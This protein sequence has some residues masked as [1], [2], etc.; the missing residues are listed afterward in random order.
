MAVCPKFFR[1]KLNLLYF[2][3]FKYFMC[4]WIW[5]RIVFHQSFFVEMQSTQLN[6]EDFSKRAESFGV[7][8]LRDPFSW[9]WKGVQESLNCGINYPTPHFGARA[10]LASIR[11][12]QNFKTFICLV[13]YPHLTANWIESKGKKPHKFSIKINYKFEKSVPGCK[14]PTIFR[15]VEKKLP[16]IANFLLLH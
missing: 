15:L 3:R 2:F 5:N 11:Q 14:R 12:V 1:G 16:T 9:D 6:C 4:F 10:G 8:L 13:Y 7:A